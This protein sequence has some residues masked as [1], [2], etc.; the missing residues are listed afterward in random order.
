MFLKVEHLENN[1]R[2]S[3]LNQDVL[4][5]VIPIRENYGLWVTRIQPFKPMGLEALMGK[6]CS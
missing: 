1:E 3:I 2:P 5:L 6:A 4:A